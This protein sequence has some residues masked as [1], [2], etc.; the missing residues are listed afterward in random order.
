MSFKGEP[1]ENVTQ[2]VI[3]PMSSLL[4]ELPADVAELMS[5]LSSA[6]QEERAGLEAEIVT[7]LPEN[8]AQAC[9]SYGAKSPADKIKVNLKLGNVLFDLYLLSNPEPKS[10]LAALVWQK[11]SM[12]IAESLDR[13]DLQVPESAAPSIRRA[14]M[15]D[16]VW[17]RANLSAWVELPADEEGQAPKRRYFQINSAGAAFFN[18][19]LAAAAT[20]MYTEDL[21]KD[22]K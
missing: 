17:S 22:V 2:T 18:K 15:D 12:E 10:P 4:G 13:E 8:L 14:L 9:Q 6:K 7:R 16:A 1:M 3:F 11:R 19:V 20:T 5:K 21:L